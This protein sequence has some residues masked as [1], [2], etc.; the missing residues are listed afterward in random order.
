MSLFNHLA[1][2]FLIC[3]YVVNALNA[4]DSET[5]VS[6]RSSTV[7]TLAADQNIITTFATIT[8]GQVS[9]SIT[10]DA[11]GNCYTTNTY[12]VLRRDVT[13]GITTVVAGSHDLSFGSSDDNIDALAGGYLYGGALGVAVDA[14]G[15]V[16][17]GNSNRIRKVDATTRILTTVAGQISP[18][19]AGDGGPGP[20]AL[21]NS[22]TD[23]ALHKSGNLYIADYR[24][25]RIRNLNIITGIITT[26][27][28]G[29]S[30]SYFGNNIPATDELLSSPSGVA[31]DDEGNVFIADTDNCCVL[32]VRSGIITTVAGICTVSG[33]NGVSG[34]VKTTRLY[35]PIAVATTPSGNFYILDFNKIMFVNVTTDTVS[36]FA[37]NGQL[38]YFGD[39][40]PAITTGMNP[41]DLALDK[42][43]TLR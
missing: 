13:T 38:K 19:F 29:N 28:G 39:G 30:G 14:E 4:A 9:V 32:K 34:P 17:F 3:L 18:G 35:Y 31:V 21:L 6:A 25:N 26:V 33:A 2:G 10:F 1:S 22:P 27:A 37:G 42:A 20:L 23:L 8:P 41:K 7:K 40:I 5:V 15:H 36:L 12:S 16:Y 43:S 24:N 11:L